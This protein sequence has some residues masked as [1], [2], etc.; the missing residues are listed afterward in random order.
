[1]FFVVAPDSYKGCVSA[2]GVAEAMER[3]ILRVFPDARVRK[4]PI[5]DGGEGK[6]EALVSAT[7]G[8]LHTSE[9]IGPMGKPVLA[10]W[11]VLGDGAT[12]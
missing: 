11:G 12:A 6:V 1:M 7:G 8:S 2:L 10:Q 3:G 4:I 9:V 5:A